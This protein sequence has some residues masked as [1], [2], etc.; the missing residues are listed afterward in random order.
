MELVYIGPVDVVDGSYEYVIRL[1]F[2]FDVFARLIYFTGMFRDRNKMKDGR[3]TQKQGYQ[4]WYQ[5]AGCIYLQSW[6]E[7]LL[8]LAFRFINSQPH[9]LLPLHIHRNPTLPSLF[10]FLILTEFDHVKWNQWNQRYWR[11]VRSKVSIKEH[12]LLNHF[13][14]HKE[15]NQKIFLFFFIL[16]IK[17]IWLYLLMYY[18][19]FDDLFDASEVINLNVL[20]E[21]DLPI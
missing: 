1:M 21:L 13:L 8:F 10:A 16:N 12:P 11:K 20:F 7:H 5:Y 2:E 6:V 14:L 3:N 19:I 18:I 9:P 15:I 17:N 4:Q